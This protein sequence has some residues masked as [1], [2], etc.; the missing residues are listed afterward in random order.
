MK[1]IKTIFLIGLLLL[2]SIMVIVNNDVDVEA[3]GGGGNGNNNGNSIGLDMEYFYNITYNL[4]RVVHDVYKGNEIRKGR[5]FGSAGDQWTAEYLFRKMNKTLSPTLEN[6]TKISIQRD[7]DKPK[8]LWKYNSIVDVEDFEITINGEGY[9]EFPHTIPKNETYIIPTGIRNLIPDVEPKNINYKHDFTDFK[10]KKR[11]LRNILKIISDHY[12]VSYV[13]VTEYNMTI[14]NATYVLNDEDLPPDQEGR[15]FLLDEEEGVNET[16]ENIT[17]NASGVI[18]I[19]DNTIGPPFEADTSKCNET[20]AI[21]RVNKEKSSIATVID[22][23]KNGTIMIADN[24]EDNESFNFSYNH[25]FTQLIL[26]EVNKC[27]F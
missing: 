9:D 10:I 24:F 5:D 2:A 17:S 14:G 8:W 27:F 7:T 4:S 1:K 26:G 25:N 12:D 21:S 20:I 19:K 15:V 16:L 18:L 3:T 22:M 6:V 13:N 11:D 23:L